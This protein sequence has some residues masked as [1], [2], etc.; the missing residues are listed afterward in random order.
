MK[1]DQIA[2]KYGWF[3]SGGI[4][5]AILA[6]TCCIGPLI[7]TILGIS[8][9]AILSK[10]E[11]L[12]TPMIAVV[13]IF[14][15]IAGVSLYRKRN[16]CD[17]ESLCAGSKKFRKMTIIYWIG[18]AAALLIITSPHWVAWLFS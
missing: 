15:G 4:V 11:I 9:A 10:F 14:F 12:R 1:T 3:F 13:F 2:A 7:L 6:S 16:M 18:L 8:G 17:P 5:A